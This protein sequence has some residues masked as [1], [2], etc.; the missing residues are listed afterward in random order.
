MAVT[1]EDSI[2][3][4]D[5]PLGVVIADSLGRS[6]SY[7]VQSDNQCVGQW[8]KV[9]G[10]WLMMNMRIFGHGTMLA[11]DGVINCQCRAINR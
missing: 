11:R 8:E 3:D 1:E 6:P 10:G 5:I 2:D 9:A 7:M 4:S